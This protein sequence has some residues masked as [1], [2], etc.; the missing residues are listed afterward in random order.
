MISG[1]SGIPTCAEHSTILE[2]K[3]MGAVPRAFITYSHNDKREKEELRTRLAVMENNGEI[4]LWDDNEILPG[5][6]WYKDIADNLANS[7][8][9]LYLVSA[10]SLASKNCNKELAEALK[11]DTRVIP[12][13]LE[14]CDWENH[15]L[16]R[17]EVLP[18]KGRPINT[19]K[20]ESDGWQNVVGGIRKTIHKMQGLEDS[21]SKISETELRAGTCVPTG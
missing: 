3:K 14:A 5:D 10:T 21:S 7:D 2:N 17:F 11:I 6:E 16:N 18:D 15:Q 12:V 20:P 9:L 1:Q 19:W 13:V 8:I 4:E